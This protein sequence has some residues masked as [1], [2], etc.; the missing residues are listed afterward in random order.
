LIKHPSYR[1]DHAFTIAHNILSGYTVDLEKTLPSSVLSA[2]DE[3]I[4]SMEIKSN[5][6]IVRTV[7]KSYVLPKSNLHVM[8][9]VYLNTPEF[10]TLINN[11]IEK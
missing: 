2:F 4:E 9:K 6:L 3:K 5:T 8:D 7:D 10:Q 1:N 11:Y